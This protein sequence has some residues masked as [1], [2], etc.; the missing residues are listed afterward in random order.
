MKALDTLTTTIGRRLAAILALAAVALLG[1][2]GLPAAQSGGGNAPLQENMPRSWYR[3]Y[4][5]GIE[6]DGNLDPSVGLYQ[7]VGKRYMLIY[8]SG[9]GT[10]YVLTLDPKVVRKVK[11][12]QISAKNDLEVVL[13]ET[14]FSESEPIPW[15]PD[16]PTAVIFYG[17][18]RKYRI[19]R[20]PPIVGETTMDEVY[21]KNP[22]YR[23]GM[24]EYTPASE[25]V[26]SLRGIQKKATIEVWFGTWCPHCKEV[27]PR[28]VKTLQAAANPNLEVRYFC[29]PRNF[30][31]YQPAV[32]KQVKAVPTFLFLRD[33][34]ELARIRGGP[35]NGSSMEAEMARILASG[36]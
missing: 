9:L 21:A 24:E 23:R 30:G 4:D 5:Y 20:V 6:V 17:G 13:A 1:P 14:S 28:L 18:E 19:A 33:G 11:D 2:G 25:A 3:N 36:S 15:M 12:G 35:R 29:V 22:I 7:L 31:K 26:S 8:G 34:R 27:V 32:E 10:A 16:G